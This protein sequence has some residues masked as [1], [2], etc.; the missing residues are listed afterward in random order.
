VTT[1]IVFQSL[2]GAAR[3]LS[4]TVTRAQVPAL[5][6]SSVTVGPTTSNPSPGLNAPGTLYY[7]RLNQIDLKFSKS[8]RYRNRK[9]VPELGIFNA[10]NSATVLSQNNVFGPLLNQVQTVLD[11]RVVRFGV[12]IDF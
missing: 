6:L 4:Y 8:L 12:Q 2:P 7:P 10:T 1:S 3:T 5:T 11:G 9:I